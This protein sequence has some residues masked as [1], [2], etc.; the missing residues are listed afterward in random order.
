MGLESNL[1]PNRRRDE[2]QSLEG[3]IEMDEYCVM[4]VNPVTGKT[5]F[6]L[7]SH[8]CPRCQKGGCVEHPMRDL[9]CQ[10]KLSLVKKQAYQA[11]KENRAEQISEE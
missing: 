7:A 6:T 9:N 4:C 2:H 5:Y 8:Y 11:F 3:G 1:D 10:I